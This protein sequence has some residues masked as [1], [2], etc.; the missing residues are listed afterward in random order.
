MKI[1]P[2]PPVDPETDPSAP[3]VAK[4]LLRFTSSDPAA[5][6]GDGRPWGDGTSMAARARAGKPPW[7]EGCRVRPMIGGYDTFDAIRAT[8]EAAIEDANARSVPP[9]GS[10][11]HVY[12]TGLQLNALRDLSPIQAWGGDRPWSSKTIVDKDQTVLGFV[13]RMIAAIDVRLLLWMPTT[14]QGYSFQQLAYEHW[15]IAAAIQDF[16]AELACFPGGGSGIVALDLRTASPTGAALH[17]KLIVV[18]VGAVNVAYCGGID[19]AFTRRDFGRKWNLPGGAGDWQSGDTTPAPEAGWPHQRYLGRDPGAAPGYPTS[20]PKW[21]KGRFPE[22]LPANVYGKGSRFWHDHHL[23]LKGP[24]VTTL[25][26]QFAERWM[27]DG[28]VFKFDRSSTVVGVDNQ[29][30]ITE[31]G[32]DGGMWPLPEAALEPAAGDA[33]VQM[34]RTIPLRKHVTKGPLRRGEFTIMAGIAKAVAQASELITIWDQYFWSEPLARLLAA[35]LNEMP[36]LRLLIVLPPYGTTHVSDELALRRFALQ[37]LWKDLRSDARSRVKVFDLWN[38]VRGVGIYVHAKVQT[39]DDMLL[40]CGSANMN[41][42]SFECDAELDCAVFHPATV[43]EHLYALHECVMAQGGAQEGWPVPPGGHG[44]EVPPLPV[45]SWRN[46][47]KGWLKEYWDDMYTTPNRGPGVISGAL[48]EDPFFKADPGNPKT[49][50]GVGMP[51]TR[52][53][54]PY[55]IFEPSSIEDGIGEAVCQHRCPGDPKAAGRLDE[56]TFL[57]ERCHDGTNWPWRVAS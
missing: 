34:W 9:G 56:L 48:I 4:W 35:R 43:R 33:T 47:G 32:P 11:G 26:Q 36:T 2:P 29:V 18:R 37:R 30:Q 12:I 1:T 54:T 50:N 28:R 3:P 21:S 49:P 40:V 27:L 13:L 7:D 46:F 8:F 41:R 6:D 51:S 17:Q 53:S 25:E 22:D 14:V 52:G 42:R 15:D 23:E 5:A 20:Y 45:P 57:I 16:N 24:I 38:W 10:K 44:D 55:S 39:Y 31:T 19:L